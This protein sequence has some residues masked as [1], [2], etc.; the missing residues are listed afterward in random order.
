MS[1]QYST[2]LR[3]ELI[4]TG[5]QSGTWGLTNNTNLGTI[6]E[7]AIAGVSGGPYISG[8]YPAVN[9]PTDADITLTANN[10]TVDQSR[11]AVLV[12]TSSGSLTSTRNVIA[13]SSASKIYII[14][15][16]TTG[17]QS[18]QIK[19]STGTGVTINNGSTILVYGDGTN[20]YLG[21]TVNN[22]TGNLTI[23]GN[24]YNSQS[25]TS[26]NVASPGV[27]TLP[28]ISSGL[29]NNTPVFFTVPAGAT[30]PT[31]LSANTTYYI[32]NLTVG[33][34]TT[35]FNLSSTVG[36]TAINT[37]GSASTG[38]ITINSAPIFAVTSTTTNY[39][40]AAN[41]ITTNSRF[42][43]A[44]LTDA[45]NT[46]EQVSS[47]A[48]ISVNPSKGSLNASQFTTSQTATVTIAS[49]AVFTVTTAPS[50]GSLIY[51]ETTGAL[52]TGITVGTNYYVINASSTTFQIASTFNGVAI[53]TSG[54]QSGT[55]TMYVPISANVTASNMLN[56]YWTTTSPQ[57]IN[58]FT[59]SISTTTL[60]VSATSVTIRPGSILSGTSVTANTQ[61]TNQLTSTG[62]AVVS[63]TYSSGGA[64]GTYV[65]T[66]S[67][68]TSIVLG[69]L[70]SGTG[71]PSNTLVT[72]INGATITLSNAFTV[73]ASGTYN[74]YTPGGVGTY[75]VNT[76]QT[77]SSTTITQ[78]YAKL[79]FAYNG[80]NV[81]VVD[82]LGNL[83]VNSL[84]QTATPKLGLGITGE[85]WRDVSVSRSFNTNYVNS[86][87]YPISV[88]VSCSF[89]S[90]SSIT[91]VVN[92]TNIIFSGFH[93]G[94]EQDNITFIVPSSST[95]QVTSTGSL[96]SVLWTE[97]Y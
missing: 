17:G 30:L 72:A 11:S 46:V 25:V 5:D 42:Y 18:I 15:N 23:S 44:V 64:I 8:T 2:N 57:T 97:L 19:Y 60:T 80:N 71:L 34:S 62:T 83:V 75:T 67:S 47:V 82:P 36:G 40:N 77:T 6:L 1:S 51:F 12:V 68:G 4:G 28:V 29:V 13:P 58:T 61:I 31:G 43:P 78:N 21:S 66:L 87:T 38:A 14:K 79:N 7:Q 76:S 96:S 45:T 63:P 89:A 55:H 3:T 91:G 59:G 86:N 20:F 27:V 9:F 95:Y 70:V 54:T 16:A 84:S 10:G 39:I 81:A 90:A 93:A 85:T 22:I 74:F 48:A 92:G 94:T 26:V 37:T 56:G 32:I 53:N 41:S 49:P 88:S 50:N 69:Q 73:Q 35:T 52:P 65:V 33:G 24:Y